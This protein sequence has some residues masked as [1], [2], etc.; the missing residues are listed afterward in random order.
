M[1][2]LKRDAHHKLGTF[3]ENF[4]E[5]CISAKSHI[6]PKAKGVVVYLKLF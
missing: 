4:H 2:G 5:V 6:S 1:L 3:S